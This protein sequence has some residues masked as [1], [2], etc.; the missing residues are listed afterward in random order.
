[1]LLD[2]E[3]KFAFTIKFGNSEITI[4]REC[5]IGIVGALLLISLLKVAR[6]L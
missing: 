1:M 5:F 6:S 2:K 3:R 4:P